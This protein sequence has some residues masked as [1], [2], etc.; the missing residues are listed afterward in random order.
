MEAN[1]IQHARVGRN[2]RSYALRLPNETY[3]ELLQFSKVRQQSV[4]LII[5]RA[6]RDFLKSEEK[7]KVR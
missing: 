4:N 6:V 5:N 2:H 3:K 1:A 7:L